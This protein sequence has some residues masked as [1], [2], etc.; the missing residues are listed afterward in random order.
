M[1][2]VSGEH[3]LLDPAAGK[4]SLVSFAEELAEKQAPKNALPKSL[5]YLRAYAE[6]IQLA[7]ITEKWL[8]GYQDFLRR[9]DGLGEST[10]GKYYA[11]V[12]FVLRRAVRDRILARKPAEAVR[13]I[14]APESV[15]VN[16]TAE[17]LG[18]SRLRASKASSA[19]RY[20]GPSSSGHVPDSASR[21]LRSLT[22][23]EIEH[24]PLQI[25]KRHGK[26]RRVIA[27]PLNKSSWKLIT[28]AETRRS[29]RFSPL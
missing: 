12:V 10:C 4:R 3:G 26:T 19:T 28:S 21:T 2:F 7:A 13:G 9:Q 16:L 14:T 29:S 1:R 15:R 11:A 22:W 18:N 24:E 6:G 25:L 17:E 23:G 8:E 5:R 27:V 20:A